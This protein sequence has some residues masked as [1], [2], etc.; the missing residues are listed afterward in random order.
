MHASMM[1]YRNDSLPWTQVAELNFDSFM[2][3][4]R[5]KT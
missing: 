2:A 5:T 1:A 4:M 3:R